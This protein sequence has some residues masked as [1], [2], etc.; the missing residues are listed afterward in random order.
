MISSASGARCQNLERGL[1]RC[2]DKAVAAAR[3][4]AQNNQ[5]AEI[6][7]LARYYSTGKCIPGDGQKAIVLYERAAALGYAP[8]YYNLGI[9]QAGG[10]H[11]YPAAEA[12]FLK[13]ASL[14]HRGCE[15][16]LGFM[17]ATT[18]PVEDDIKAFGWLSLA[19]ARHPPADP[20]LTKELLDKVTHRLRADQREKANADLMVLI[21]KYGPVP[22][23]RP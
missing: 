10:A 17:Y 12:Y 4:G 2:S 15:F 22:A 3:A 9:I 5:P 13:G 20:E 1:P 8:A 11:D 19:L 18:P 21:A 6:Y 16:M 7:K 23:F 14:G